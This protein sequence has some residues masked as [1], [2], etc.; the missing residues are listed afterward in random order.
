MVFWKSRM[1]PAGSCHC[2]PAAC[3]NHHI[4]VPPDIVFQ[5]CAARMDLRCSSGKGV[6][7]TYGMIVSVG[8]FPQNGM[9]QKNYFISALKLMMHV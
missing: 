5:R 4:F 7:L 2:N 8:L 6:A 3:S 1:L 9:H